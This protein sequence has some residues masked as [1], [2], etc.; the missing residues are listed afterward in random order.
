M[1]VIWICNREAAEVSDSGADIMMGR[2]RRR[3]C[4]VKLAAKIQVLMILF[5]VSGAFG[6]AVKEA[7]VPALVVG[8]GPPTSFVVEGIVRPSKDGGLAFRVATDGQKQ[9]CALYD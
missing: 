8:K 6:A 3:R 1:L 4:P 7:S 5:S 2:K 9:I